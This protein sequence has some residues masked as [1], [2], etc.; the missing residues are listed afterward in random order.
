[1]VHE[2][3]ILSGKY[4]LNH[5]LPVDTNRGKTYNPIFSKIKSLLDELTDIANKYNVSPAQIATAWAIG[6][7][8]TPILEAAK[9]EQVE[10]TKISK[11]KFISRRN[12]LSI[13]PNVNTRGGWEG[14]V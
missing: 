5:L 14:Q 8:T 6:R 1:M 3:G 9:V 2:Q 7:G 11:F 10:D 12:E 4:N 13:A